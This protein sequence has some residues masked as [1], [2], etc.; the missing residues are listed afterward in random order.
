MSKFKL[1]GNANFRQF[2]STVQFLLL[3]L[4]KIHLDLNP[5]RPSFTTDIFPSPEYMMEGPQLARLS[6][7]T[8]LKFK[9][10]VL[11][12]AFL[13]PN[14]LLLISKTFKAILYCFPLSLFCSLP[15]PFQGLSRTRFIGSASFSHTSHL[16][17]FFV[18]WLCVSWRS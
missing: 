16:I 2:S 8:Q 11:K 15:C 5:R 17:S 4:L 10:K 7:N 3:F 14:Y 13:S 9:E 12:G 18:L 6:V 1:Q